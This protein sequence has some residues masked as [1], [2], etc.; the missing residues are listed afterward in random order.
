[1]NSDLGNGWIGSANIFWGGVA[2][3]VS[4]E[5]MGGKLHKTVE[6]DRPGAVGG[7]C[8]TAIRFGTGPIHTVKLY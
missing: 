1:V 8:V 4:V 2:E 5:R 7:G 6:E 3:G